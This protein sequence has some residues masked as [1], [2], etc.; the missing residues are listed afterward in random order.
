[1][2]DTAAREAHK[3]RLQASQRFTEVAA[4]AMPLVGVLWHEGEHIDIDG[5]YGEEEHF[6]VSLLP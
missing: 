2:Y 1:M 5:A 4:E 6:E 3:F